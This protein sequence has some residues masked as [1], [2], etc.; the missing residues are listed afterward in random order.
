MIF[1][2]EV[3]HATMQG[4]MSSSLAI[5]WNN[6]FVAKCVRDCFGL[7][8]V[9][10]FLSL[11]IFPW[12]N[13]SFFLNVVVVLFDNSKEFDDIIWNMLQI[14]LKYILSAVHVPYSVSSPSF[15]CLWV[16]YLF[17]EASTCC[18]HAKEQTSIEDHRWNWILYLFFLYHVDQLISNVTSDA[19]NL[20]YSRTP[21]T[22]NEGCVTSLTILPLASLCS[23]LRVQ[24]PCVRYRADMYSFL[25]YTST[26]IIT[27]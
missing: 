24:V 18:P 9:L 26:K 15:R 2:A 21:K 27:C 17:S 13:K 3:L 14:A 1:L 16:P 23:C 6:C 11:W 7:K 12:R 25:S 22:L 10:K 8:H 20:A 19:S 4:L 5:L